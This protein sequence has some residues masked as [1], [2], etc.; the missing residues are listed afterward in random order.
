MKHSQKLRTGSLYK[1]LMEDRVTYI[2]IYMYVNVYIKYAHKL[3]TG[4]QYKW[5]MEDRITSRCDGRKKEGEI[6][7]ANLVSVEVA[8][9]RS[10]HS[11]AR[12]V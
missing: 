7:R 6:K 9:W 10:R 11:G 1:W 2:Y 8:R 4:S 3:R 5:L 12:L